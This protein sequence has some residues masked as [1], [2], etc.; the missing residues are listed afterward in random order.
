[1]STL[2][3][4][5]PAYNEEDGIANIIERV[6]K[7]RPEVKQTGVDDIE[8][9]VVDD[10][11]KD[12]TAEIVRDFAQRDVGVRLIQH[13]RN[14]NYGGALKTGFHHARGDLLAFLDADGTYPPE[15]FPKMC[16][17]ALSGADMVVGTR[18]VG[19]QNDS[20]R[21]RQIGNFMFA[22]LVSLIGATRV[23]DVASGMRVFKR[24]VLDRLYPLPDGLNFTPAMSTRAIHE[25]IQ[26]A[27][28]PIPHGERLGH[29]KL[30]VLRDGWRFLSAIVWTA[31]TYNPARI[32][33]GI[34]LAGM[35]LALIVAGVLAA[36]RASGVAF[37]DAWG[38]F[39]LHTAV[40]FGV[41]GV[42]VFTLGMTFNYLV[43]LFHRRPVRQSI[44]RKPLFA[45]PLDRQFWWIGASAVGIGIG[46]GMFS[47]IMSA[48]SWPIERL[49]FWLLISAMCIVIGV[50]LMISWFVMRTLEEL[51][52][53]DGKTES[54]LRGSL[55]K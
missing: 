27:E 22:R 32:F 33:G 5:I 29:S 18:M 15:Y 35:L 55:I 39:V 36:L 3:V 47:L 14:R 43:S 1:M 9:I 2:S 19:E 52:Q 53:R 34:G 24:D 44:F 50:Q 21:I 16:Q 12:R 30:G 40:V 48:V 23:T 10:G 37:L 8:L 54:D 31:L 46:L 20:P 49:W 41:A 25:G 4:V 13:A 45:R 7:V 6:L 51:S 28:V 42:S 11:S 17:A 38:V 26:L